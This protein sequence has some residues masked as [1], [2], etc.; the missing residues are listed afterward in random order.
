MNKQFYIGDRV[1]CRGCGRELDGTVGVVV[2]I[3]A[4]GYYEIDF[5]TRL[6]LVYRTILTRVASDRLIEERKLHKRE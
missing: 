2:G 1:M 4:S 5:G 3:F 6:R